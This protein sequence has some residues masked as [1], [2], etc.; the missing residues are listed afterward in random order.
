ML[1]VVL[2]EDTDGLLLVVILLLRIMSPEEIGLGPRN[3]LS[4]SLTTRKLL[5]PVFGGDL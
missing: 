5:I 3:N 2:R 1:V 4:K